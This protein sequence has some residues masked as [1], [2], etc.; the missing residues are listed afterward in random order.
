MKLAFDLISDLRVSSHTE[1]DWTSQ[2]TSP[3]CV[4]AGDVAH[5]HSEL[6]RVLKHLGKNY[7]AV[8]YIDGND[9]HRHALETLD[10]NYA[11]VRAAVEGIDNVTYMHDHVVIINGVAIIATNGWW[12]FDWSKQFTVEET[13]AGVEN[14][15]GITNI[16]TSL[17]ESIANSD[18]LYLD[19]SIARLQT[20]NDV[21]RIVI[22]THTVPRGIFLQHDPDLANYR[23]NSSINSNITMG[24]SSDTEKKVT[25]WCFGHYH[26]PVDQ[27][28]D[29]VRYVSNPRGRIDSP[30]HR[31]PYF[32][33]R[34]EV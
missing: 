26:W 17:I 19:R 2:A 22:V 5:D 14:H 11:A 13:K 34:I 29:N 31:N 9:E 7:Q 24:L 3:I 20:F 30:W 4:V 10:T 8:F 16:G 18:S 25:T 15:Y 28:I 27:V 23:I 1:F 6:R 21:K 32:P 12:S 33:I